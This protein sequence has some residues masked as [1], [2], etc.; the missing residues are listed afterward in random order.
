MNILIDRELREAAH[1]EVI[2]HGSTGSVTSGTR[3]ER[4][5]VDSVNSVNSVAGLQN[6]YILFTSYCLL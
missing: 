4:N 1:A 6:I 5:I 2:A 3:Y